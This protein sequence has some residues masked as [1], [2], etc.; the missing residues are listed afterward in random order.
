LPVF[1]R[2]SCAGTAGTKPILPGPDGLAPNEDVL[3]ILV[4][5][6][7]CRLNEEEI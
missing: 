1:S 6:Y 4:S 5:E 7:Y 3:D 2:V